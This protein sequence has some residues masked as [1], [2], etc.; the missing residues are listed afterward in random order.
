M[1]MIESLN[2]KH[3]AIH[4]E[5]ISSDKKIRVEFWV[6]YCDEEARMSTYLTT[7]EIAF[8]ID[9]IMFMNLSAIKSLDG[10]QV[11]NVSK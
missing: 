8:F 9:L 10:Y 4:F 5:E 3:Y 6:V 1:K 11:A 2:G 7:K